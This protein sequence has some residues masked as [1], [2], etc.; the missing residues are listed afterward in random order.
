M[1]RLYH[2]QQDR[3]RKESTRSYGTAGEL[4]MLTT[5]FAEHADN[6]RGLCSI[7]PI[8][9]VV[10]DTPSGFPPGTGMRRREFCTGFHLRA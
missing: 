10:W 5:N 3:A 8:R 4:E 6:V 7:W 9:I 1:P 2:E